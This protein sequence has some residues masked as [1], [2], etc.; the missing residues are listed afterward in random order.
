MKTFHLTLTAI[1]LLGLTIAAVAQNDAINS[2]LAANIINNAIRQ[3][4]DEAQHRFMV[5]EMLDGNSVTIMYIAYRRGIGVSDEQNEIIWEGRQKIE[6]TYDSNTMPDDPDYRA[7]LEEGRQLRQALGAAARLNPPDMNAIEDMKAQWV[8]IQVRQQTLKQEKYVNLFYDTLTPEQIK[9]AQ[10]FHLAVMAETGF[11]S[12]AMFEALDL[13]DAQKKQFDE[14]K[15]NIAPELNKH[16]GKQVEWESKFREKLRNEFR[17]KQDGVSGQEARQKVLDDL[18]KKLLAEFQPER[19]KV[20]ESGKALGD[21]LKVE[22]FDVL[23]DEQ[24]ARLMELIDNPPDYVKEVLKKMREARAE[25]EKAGAWVPGPN[26]WRPG[27]PIPEGYRQ[28]R[29]EGRFPRNV[30]SE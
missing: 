27:D 29:Q 14:I 18:Q 22:M 24:W 13:S 30:Q 9:K 20:Q 28:Q 19:D 23:T 7:V 10:E 2:E 25:N 5:N 16:V 12:P 3:T 1:L 8:D 4:A 15:R 11:V 26:S 6:Q 17:E 21:K